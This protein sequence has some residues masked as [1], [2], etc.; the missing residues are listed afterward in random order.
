MTLIWNSTA[1]FCNG[2][3]NFDKCHYI[4]CLCAEF[5]AK[6][7]NS[8]LSFITP[9]RMESDFGSWQSPDISRSHLYRGTIAWTP[10]TAIYREYTVLT[11]FS[12][13]ILAS[14]AA[15]LTNDIPLVPLHPKSNSYFCA[16]ALY[17]QN[18]SLI[19]GEVSPSSRRSTV[20]SQWPSV[21]KAARSTSVTT[22][23]LLRF[24]GEM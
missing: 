14:A 2:R 24:S 1:Q 8:P 13:N 11:K 6:H 19:S 5:A 4:S 10:P 22:R 20:A 15:G 23:G 18:L 16:W 9:W 21:L 12:W 3:S 7:T 17:A